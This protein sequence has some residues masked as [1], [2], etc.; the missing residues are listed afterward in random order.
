MRIIRLNM[1]N[2]ELIY[3]A[4]ERDYEVSDDLR[5]YTA[6]RIFIFFTHVYVQIL[7][8]AISEVK[9]FSLWVICKVGGSDPRTFFSSQVVNQRS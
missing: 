5:K 2:Q 6:F 3:S 9:C 4:G 8:R 7:Y 1:I